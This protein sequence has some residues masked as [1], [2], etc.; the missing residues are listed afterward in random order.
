MSHG[1][2]AKGWSGA[3]PGAR[4]HV[5]EGQEPIGD[6]LCEEGARGELHLPKALRR[7]S[8]PQLNPGMP[9]SSSAPGHF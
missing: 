8:N 2:W 5:A 9:Q 3:S 7:V 6:A 1:Q 4:D